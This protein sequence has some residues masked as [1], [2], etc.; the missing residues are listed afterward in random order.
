MLDRTEIEKIIKSYDYYNVIKDSAKNDT[1][2][3]PTIAQIN[4]FTGNLEFI[5]EEE[6]KDGIMLFKIDSDEGMEDLESLT[7][8]E[9]K[10][11]ELEDITPDEIYT[12]YADDMTFYCKDF[13][14]DEINEALDKIY[15][16]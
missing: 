14:W 16:R 4:L 7:P 8:D 11:M 9:L 3:I 2:G 15:K 1:F 6:P 5:H 12:A 13:D 10:A